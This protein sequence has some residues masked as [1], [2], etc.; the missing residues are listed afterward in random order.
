LMERWSSGCA[1]KAAQ[2]GGYWSGWRR[3]LECC[4]LVT[5]SLE[6]VRCDGG[7]VEDKVSV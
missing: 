2:P 3:G 4:G 5:K 1:G 6:R 7:G